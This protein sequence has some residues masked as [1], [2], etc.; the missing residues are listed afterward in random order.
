MLTIITL[1]NN[2]FVLSFM[3]SL[4]QSVN[5]RAAS[6]FAELVQRIKLKYWKMYAT[7]QFNSCCFAIN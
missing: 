5:L 2:V 7:C 6:S 3:Y 1:N 4:F